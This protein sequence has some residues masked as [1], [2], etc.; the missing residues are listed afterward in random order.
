M[1]HYSAQDDIPQGQRHIIDADRNFSLSYNRANQVA[2]KM[3]EVLE[4][5]GDERIFGQ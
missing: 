3:L 2:V 1:I 5:R 4:K